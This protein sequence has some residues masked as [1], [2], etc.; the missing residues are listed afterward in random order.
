MRLPSRFRERLG[1][2]Q[3]REFRLLWI[4]QSTSGIGDSLIPVAIAFAVLHIG[5]SATAIGLVLASFTLPRVILILVGG[6]WADRLP[7]QLVMIAADVVRGVTEL[8]IAALL[9]SGLAQL[10]EMTAG[11]ALIGAA[12]AFFA[13]AVTGLIPQTAS[14]GRLQQANALMSL[15]RSS[16]GILGPS[17]AGILVVTVGPGWVFVIDAATY[18]ASAVSLSLLRLRT[19]VTPE[20]RRGFLAEVAAGWHEVASRRWLLAAILTFGISNVAMGPVYVLGPVIA[21]ERLG[22]AASWGL[23][24]TAMG[25]GGLLGG[26]AALRWR[27]HRPLFTGFGIGV[28]FSFPM[29]A[30]AP[31][32]PLPLIMLAGLLAL[33][34]IELGNTWWYTV[35]QQRIPAT[36]LSRVSSYDWLASSAFQPIGF[37]ITGP[38]AA[39]P[40]V[41]VS[42][43]LVGAGLLSLASNLGV[44]T[45]RELRNLTWMQRE[46]EE[47]GGRAPVAQGPLVGP[48]ELEER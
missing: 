25:I 2:L 24:V 38:I 33:M 41:G 5:G 7:R 35:L 13:P 27:P 6:V 18:A 10:W 11:A 48:V 36:A 16:S 42:A 47:E 20:A 40:A 15:S 31:P 30:L 12:G 8:V 37:A 43:T 14:P 21:N 39:L 29:F 22:G 4:G 26:L 9:I 28:A 23:I 1:P 34:A 44:L 45:V 46:T 19:S 3:E 17:V 32:M